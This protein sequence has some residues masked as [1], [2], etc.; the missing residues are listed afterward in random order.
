MV[1]QNHKHQI[2]VRFISVL[3]LA[4]SCLRLAA[5][6]LTLQYQGQVLISGVPYEG[7]A[8]FKFALVDANATSLWS[9]DSS[10]QSGAEP[11]TALMLPVARGLYSIRLGDTRVSGM[12]PIP[13]AVFTN[14]VIRLRVW[15][16]DGTNGV[17]QLTPDREIGSVAFAVRSRTAEVAESLPA[18]L[19]TENHLSTQLRNALSDLEARMIALSNLVNN[20]QG[21]TLSQVTNDVANLVALNEKTTFVSTDAQDADLLAAGASVFRKI[22]STAWVSGPAGAPAARSRHTG[23]WTGREFIVWGGASSG[24]NVLNSGG[25][26]DPG[27]NEWVATTTIDAPMARHR[28]GSVWTGSR[29][30]VWGG[31]EGS[32]W[33]PTGGLYDPM[34]QRWFPVGK[35]PLDGREDHVTLW[36]GNR[37]AIWGGRNAHG[38]LGDGALYDPAGN[39]WTS[40]P[41]MGPVPV[42]RSGATAVWTGDTMIVWGGRSATVELGDGSRLPIVNGMPGN[43]QPMSRM[44]GPMP[45]EGHTAVWTGEEM[46]V[47]GGKSAGNF[48]N[49]GASY[50]PM[51]DSW[52]RLSMQGA[53]PARSGHNA[54]WSGT[55]MVII[56][57]ED[58]DGEMSAGAAYDPATDTW[59]NLTSVGAPVARANAT[60]VWN[61]L[62]LIVFG[63]EAAGSP[64]A[65]LQRL[66]PD[67]PV[68]LY[69]KP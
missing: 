46:I 8:R 64:L 12:A 28:H 29:M 52:S 30:F 15:F 18:G 60:A 42:A 33:L 11:T 1:R 7:T 2:P 19:V 24:N 63:G 31:H 55:E 20:V 16:N 38:R 34:I 37:V 41:S 58:L 66:N 40:L 56:G 39:A 3:F 25:K 14:E 69:R 47:W 32:M 6:P 67:P 21:S 9:H 45:R 51:T 35:G 5:V 44:G 22:D 17:Q 59:R 57:G 13:A 48:L 53:P 27:A 26:F 10:S 4:V 43:W 68:F 62:Q 54:V 50:N 61:G 36:T 65:A 23:V 49:D